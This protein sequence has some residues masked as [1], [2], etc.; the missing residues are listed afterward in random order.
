MP[1]EKYK[2]ELSEREIR[3]LKEITRNG[4]SNTEK[5]IM[6]ANILLNTNDLSSSKRTNRELSEIFG[7]SKT[8]VNQIR[9]T[10]AN[11][12]I[13]AA[14][15]RKTRITAPI[16]SKT[17]GEFE[18]HV[19]ATALKPAPKGRARW[20]LR[21]SAEHCME[22][23]YIVTISHTCIGEMLNT[24]QV[25]P[26][27]SEY[28][29][30]PKENDANFVANME[31]VL[32]IYQKQYNKKMPVLCMDEK[33]IQFL[34]ETRQR[35]AAKPLRAD[36]DT[37]IPKPGTVEKADAEYIRCGHGGI[38][39][40]TE[41]LAGRRHVVARETRTKGDF[42]FLMRQVYQERYSNAE[43]VILV[44]DNLNTHGKASFYEAFPA[45][46]A[47]ESALKYEF[48][49]TPVHGSWLN[50]AE[51][52]LSSLAKECLGKQRINCIEAL[53]DILSFWEKD[54]NTRQKGVNWQFTAQDARTKLKRL[55]PTPMF[56]C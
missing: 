7:V 9:K 4:S 40:F 50:I 53:N 31:D 36:P 38:F 48:H 34:D 5:K 33:P 2:V 51:C 1:K 17:T 26:H 22:N 21:L 54:K 39:I 28:R 42:A 56:D 12:G 24:N 37:D 19:I 6:H 10:Y 11:E 47:Y 23:Q 3:L 14:L 45:P 52:E 18:A 13:E 44:A 29:C 8:T 43:K 41:P 27:L 46:T 25:K 49:Y 55:Y 20:T 35:I 30:I 15:N 32:G 16:L